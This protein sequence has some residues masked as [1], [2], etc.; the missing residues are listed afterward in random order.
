VNRSGSSAEGQ[1][2]VLVVDDEPAIRTLIAA[3]LHAHGYRVFQAADGIQAID[4]AT[5]YRPDLILLDVALPLLSGHEVCRRLRRSSAT[6]STPVLLLSGI[7]SR[8]EAELARSLGAQGVI[9][10]PFTPTDLL[11]R[12]AEALRRPAGA[13]SS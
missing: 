13:R 12:V 10:K 11:R 5:T 9:A 7:A 2:A 8:A 1:P 3:A 6:A 4:I